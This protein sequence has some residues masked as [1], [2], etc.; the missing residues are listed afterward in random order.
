MAKILV[1]GPCGEVGRRVIFQLLQQ[2]YE[3]RCIALPT[4]RY[5]DQITK[6]DVDVVYDSPLMLDGATR[7]IQSVDGI[8]H[9]AITYS[10]QKSLSEAQKYNEHVMMTY[11]LATAAAKQGRCR[12]VYNSSSAVYPNDTHVIEACYHPIDELHPLRPIGSYAVSKLIGENL[13]RVIYRES[14]MPFSVVRES[15]VVAGTAILS[16]FTV[17]FVMNILKIGQHKSNSALYMHDN[18]ELWH[19]LEAASS[20]PDQPCSVTNMQGDPW[21]Y[22]VVHAADVA[23]C[24]ITALECPAAINEVFNVA[25][26]DYINYKDA[27]ELLAESSGLPVLHWKVPVRWIFD[28]EIKKAKSYMN[29]MPSW[30]MERMLKTAYT[31]KTGDM[32]ILTADLI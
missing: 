11:N 10:P 19:D 26:P 21:I 13:L 5:L 7:A 22:Q 24:L 29:Y 8:I 20:S 2:G 16:R 28:L 6:W 1:T 23:Q 9:T 30:G 17:G 18:T 14:E 31:I 27:A 4:D 25:A 3:V 12:F 15:G 32:D